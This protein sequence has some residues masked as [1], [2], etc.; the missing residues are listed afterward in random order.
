MSL[1]YQC[2]FFIYFYIFNAMIRQQVRTTKVLYI[3]KKRPYFTAI[4]FIIFFLLISAVKM[5]GIWWQ[6]SGVCVCS[7]TKPTQSVRKRELRKEHPCAFYKW[8][9]SLLTMSLLKY[10]L[11]LGFVDYEFVGYA[12]YEFKKENRPRVMSGLKLV[13]DFIW[14]QVKK[15]NR[16]RSMSGLKLVKDFIWWQERK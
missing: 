2:G 15:E 3:G 10:W 16:P 9:R 5:I 13:V 11:W 4:F 7:T 12:I 6:S 1:V 14:W 8:G